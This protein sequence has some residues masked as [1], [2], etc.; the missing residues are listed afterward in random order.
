MEPER[1][2]EPFPPAAQKLQ[3]QF[4]IAF[5]DPAGL[6]AERSEEKCQDGWKDEADQKNSGP[7]QRIPALFHGCIDADGAHQSA[8]A[9]TGACGDI[10]QPEQECGNGACHHGGQCGRN[11]DT[12]ITDNIA[13]LQHRGSQS[14]GQQSAPAIFTET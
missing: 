12:G 8:S 4:H 13:H 11:P 10:F 14:L 5:M 1:A 6:S 2:T 3:V 9:H 7:H